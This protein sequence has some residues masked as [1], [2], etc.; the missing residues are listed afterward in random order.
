MDDMT[1]PSPEPSPL[2]DALSPLAERLRKRG[3]EIGQPSPGPT[4]VPKETDDDLEARRAARLNNYQSRWAE[5][6][7]AMYAD[8]SL[9]NLTDAQHHPEI[10]RWM[11][12][13]RL[14]LV[15]A[16]GV[17]TGKTYA[18]YAIG[19]RL[20]ERGVWV[21]AWPVGDL[22]D[23]LRPTSTDRD[24]ERRARDCQVLILDDLTA[25]ATEWEAE[26]LTLLMDARV[27][28]KRRTIV[29]TNISAAQI[30][31]AWGNRLMD[32]LRWRLISCTFT[33]PSRRAEEW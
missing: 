33:G 1:T 24:A 11:A 15:L 31:E 4:P 14:H 19:N 12:E 17:G 18:A 25:K 21:E 27:R 13:D 2:A 10:L 22:M 9:D 26:R 32:R 28:S 29:T 20:L 6:L 16:G 8:A 30:A 5:R 23:A 7:P 3:L